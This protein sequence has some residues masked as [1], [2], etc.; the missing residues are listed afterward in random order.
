MELTQARAQRI[1]AR[2]R[3]LLEGGHYCGDVGC[4]LSVSETS[5]MK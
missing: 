4:H 3:R 1:K 2:S 5:P